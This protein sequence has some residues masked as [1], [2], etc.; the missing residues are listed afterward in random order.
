MPE[1]RSIEILCQAFS[2]VSSVLCLR[3]LQIR[4]GAQIMKAVI[5]HAWV[6]EFYFFN[7]K[8]V[9]DID[10]GCHAGKSTGGMRQ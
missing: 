3:L 9:A 5:S 4:R 1:N 8:W 2:G 6:E 7:H 10:Y